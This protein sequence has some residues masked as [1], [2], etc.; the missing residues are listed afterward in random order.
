MIIHQ[1]LWKLLAMLMR[2]RVRWMFRGGRSGRSIT[3]L[4]FG[5]LIVGMALLGAIFRHYKFGRVD[6]S[7][8]TVYLPVVLLTFCI[9]NLI[10]AV[11]G[12]SMMAARSY[13]TPT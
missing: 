7:A 4:I 6:P 13:M 3:F 9:A 5:F 8:V 11:M 2:A 1:S 10:S 12:P